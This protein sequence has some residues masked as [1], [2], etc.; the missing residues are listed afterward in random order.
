MKMIKNIDMNYEIKMCG[1]HFRIPIGFNNNDD[2]NNV[3]LLI[4]SPNRG[5]HW[6]NPPTYFMKFLY[7]DGG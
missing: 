1:V 5:L 7:L 2:E 6:S 3:Y 4:S